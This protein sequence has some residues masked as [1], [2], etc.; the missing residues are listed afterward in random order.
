MSKYEAYG[1]KENYLEYT[2]KAWSRASDFPLSKETVY[3]EHKIVQEFDLIK[4][5]IVLEYACGAGSDAI[6]YLKR[7]NFVALC[8]ITPINI[9][10]ARKN[11]GPFSEKAFF[12]V[13]EDSHILPFPDNEFDII[14]MHG[15]CM[16]ILDPI[17]TLQALYRVLRHG[18]A[19][20]VMLYTEY[21]YQRAEEQVKY[22]MEHHN[23]SQWE[24]FCWVTDGP[25]SPYA[26]YYTEQEGRELFE[27][28]GFGI[29]KISLYNNNDFRTF[30]LMK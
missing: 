2:K 1:S 14:N 19:M 3:P 24:A 10:N 15:V 13:L 17:P 9:E 6:S 16:H 22:L 20:Y 27:P 25:N 28:I 18:G 30:K 11:V 21:L 7:G 4:D 29:E 5:S 12:Y 23:I 26:R 8:D